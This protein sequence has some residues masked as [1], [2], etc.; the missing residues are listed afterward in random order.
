M[1]QALADAHHNFRL[2]RS[3]ELP[4]MG[5]YLEQTTNY[6]N[7]CMAPLGCIQVTGS[8]IRNYVKMGLVRNPIKKL[9]YADHIQHIISIT[10]LKT[11]MSLEHIG[12]MFSWQSMHYPAPVAYDYLCRELENMLGYRFGWLEQLNDTADSHTEEKTTLHSA[13]IAVSHIIYMNACFEW[14]KKNS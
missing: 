7:Q 11:V 8:M 5:L 10:L 9:Y 13:I 6:I 4:N 1:E 2:P 12:L 3:H 14:L